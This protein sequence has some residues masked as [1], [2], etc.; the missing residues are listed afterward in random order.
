MDLILLDVFFLLLRHER[1]GCLF[2]KITTEVPTLATG[3]ELNDEC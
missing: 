2:A 1:L 3:R